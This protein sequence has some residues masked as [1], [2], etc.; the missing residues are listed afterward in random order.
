MIVHLFGATSSLGCANYALKATA[1]MFEKD[2][3]KLTSV[4]F[5]SNFYVDD[6]LNSLATPAETLQLVGG[7]FLLPSPLSYEPR[8]IIIWICLVTLFPSNI[9]LAYNG[10]SSRTRSSFV[11]K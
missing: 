7:K 11:L 9:L 1:D 6:G 10:A 4:F 3:G 8:T 5:G 2:C